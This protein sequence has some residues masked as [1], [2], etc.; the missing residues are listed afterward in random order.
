MKAAV[1]FVVI[2]IIVL[3]IIMFFIAG[4]DTDS[5]VSNEGAGNSLTSTQSATNNAVSDESDNNNADSSSNNDAIDI[6]PTKPRTIEMSSSGFN[7]RTIE[8]NQGESVIFLNTGTASHWPASDIHPTHKVY[9][10]SDIKKCGSSESVRIFDSCKGLSSGE[11]Y[12][13]TFTE[14]GNWAYHDHLRPSMK[15]IIIVR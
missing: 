14:R 6:V 1:I 9:P 5:L 12:I 2:A 10:G 13:F 3:G 11:S 7:P 15:G 4:R 8:I